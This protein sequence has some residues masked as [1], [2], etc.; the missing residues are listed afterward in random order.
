MT[1]SKDSKRRKTALLGMPVGTAERKLRKAI[2]HELA[3][4]CGRNVCRWCSLEIS[5]PEDVAVIHVEDWEEFPDRY[6]DLGNVALSHV[7]CAAARGGRRQG[8]ESEM[9]IEV[10]VEDA[11]GNRLPG[12]RHEGDLYVAGRKGKRYQVRVRNRTGKNLLLVTTVDGRNVQTSE[13]G[14]YDGPGHVLGPYQTWVF[15]GWRTSNSEVAAFEFGSK[16]DAYSSQLGSSENVG[17]IGVAV[18][19]EK[20][21]DPKIVT[22]RETQFVPLPYIVERPAP[23]PWGGTPWV[24]W[25]SSTGGFSS[26]GINASSLDLNLGQGITSDTVQVNSVNCSMDSSP[27]M[28]SSLTVEPASSTVSKRPASKRSRSRRGSKQLRQE[29]GTE[30]GEQLSS[31]VVQTKFERATEDPCEVHA[32]RYDSAQALRRQGI[33]VD[34]PSQRPEK[35]PSPFPES[36][37]GY[38]KPPPGR[39]ARKP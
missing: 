37:D 9:R 29:L 21:P 5:D 28:S 17:V 20:E 39:H 23:R 19:E 35:R 31:S 24:T 27:T 11:H 8:D 3:R 16:G 30:F 15:K 34:R 6:F 18:F 12:A 13:P 36:Q 1:K 22:I 33:R 32:V 25:T 14:D 10:S 4:Q 26:P 7:S 38:C 2:I